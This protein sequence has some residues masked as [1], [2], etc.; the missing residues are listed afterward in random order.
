MEKGKISV[1]M[2]A[3]N[4]EKYIEKA[5]QSVMHQTYENFELII[6]ED[7]S[8]DNT[9]KICQE[10][11]TQSSK[12]KL[13]ENKENS[14]VS[15][16]RNAGIECVTGEYIYFMD[17]DDYIEKDMFQSLMNIME[18]YH[19]DLITTG[20]FSEVE[21][22]G[23]KIVDE[24]YSAEKFYQ[25]KEEIKQDFIEMWEKH[26][27]YTIGNKLYLT[28][29]IEDYHLRFQTGN[30]GEDLNFNRNYL[31]HAQKVYNTAKCYYHYIRERAGAATK[32]YNPN[33]FEVRVKE[34]KDFADFFEKYGLSHEQ[35]EHFIAKRYMERTLGCIENLFHQECTLSVK[36]KR[37]KIKEIIEHEETRKYLKIFKPNS[38]KVAIMLIPYRL[39]M[40][41]LAMIMGKFL[42]FVKEKL[43]T[44]FNRLKNR[45]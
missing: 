6:V 34:N 26:I 33:L 27:Y 17:S 9:K 15:Y 41:T 8:H 3:Y 30:W 44:V 40:Y 37:Q 2:P 7:C 43:P 39:H 36:E 42:C 5:I 10:Q 11:M 28:K 14:G 16:S 1:I 24:I 20:F 35:Y 23:K 13:I 32:K 45:R 31:L 21:S 29:I 25:N 12:I 22:N 4:T 19:P 18:N 38:K